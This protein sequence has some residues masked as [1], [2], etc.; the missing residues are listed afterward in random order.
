[1]AQKNSSLNL[2]SQLNQWLKITDP[3]F[4]PHFSAVIITMEKFPASAINF[5]KGKNRF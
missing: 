4:A 2:L 3:I 1:M 5:T